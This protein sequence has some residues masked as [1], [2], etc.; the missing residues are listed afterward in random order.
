MN[1]LDKQLARHARIDAVGYDYHAQP[2]VEIR[3]C[4]LCNCGDSTTIACADRYGFTVPSRLCHACGFV[5]L[6]PRLSPAAYGEFYDHWYRRLACAYGGVSPEDTIGDEVAQSYAHEIANFG[7][8][9]FQHPSRNTLLD[10][11]GSKGFLAGEFIQRWNYHATVVEPCPHEAALAGGMGCDVFV[12]LLEEYD[13]T[14]RF[15]VISLLQTVDHLLDLRGALDKVHRLLKPSGLFLVDFVNWRVFADRFGP[16][17]AAKIDHPLNFTPDTALVALLRGGF[18]PLRQV[19]SD[20]GRHLVYLCRPV[21]PIADAM[22]SA[23]SVEEMHRRFVA[24]EEPEVV[25]A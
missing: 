15:D 7:R 9:F 6:S 3:R 11:G 17:E 5:W 20:D 21:E 25:S 19:A 1:N 12:G 10:I 23:R 8:P 16:V 24:C 2:K 13:S 4:P 18:E 14:E 22:P